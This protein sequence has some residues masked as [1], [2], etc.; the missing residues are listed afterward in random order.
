MFV[1]QQ[2]RKEVTIACI[3]DLH[4]VYSS[5]SGKQISEYQTMSVVLKEKKH[6]WEAISWQVNHNHTSMV[7]NNIY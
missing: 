5:D 4:L 6:I 3:K 7:E 1:L 2:K